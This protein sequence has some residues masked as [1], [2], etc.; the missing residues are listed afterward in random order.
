MHKESPKNICR[1]YSDRGRQLSHSYLPSLLFTWTKGLH[2]HYVYESRKQERNWSGQQILHFL[3]YFAGFI[4]H[5]SM[6]WTRQLAAQFADL[7][8]AGP[9]LGAGEAE[10]LTILQ[11]KIKKSWRIF[12][13]K[14]KPPKI[15]LFLVTARKLICNSQFSYSTHITF[16]SGQLDST[17]APQNVYS[18]PS[19]E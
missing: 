18:N 3:H 5:I 13:E 2:S 10:K 15:H 4:K 1:W 14:Q 8:F 11:K 19:L 12:F 9:D 6:F 17:R 7:Q 16:F